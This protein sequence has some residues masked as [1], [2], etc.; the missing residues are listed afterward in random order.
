[1]VVREDPP[2]VAVRKRLTLSLTFDHRLVDGAPAARFL[3]RVK[4]L[5]ERPEPGRAP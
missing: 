2:E 4:Q 1:V 3:Q 5:V